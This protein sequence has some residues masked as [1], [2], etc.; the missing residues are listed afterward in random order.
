[1]EIRWMN[2]TWEFHYYW[3]KS[4]KSIIWMGIVQWRSEWPTL[5]L[6]IS[7]GMKQSN[8]PQSAVGRASCQTGKS[9]RLCLNRKL[10]SHTQEDICYVWDHKQQTVNNYLNP[11]TSLC[12]CVRVC[13][14][15]CTCVHVCVYRPAH[16][17]AA[18]W[19]QEQQI[20]INT[21]QWQREQP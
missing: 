3:K 19:L 5:T 13:V 4:F 6:N 8:R 21:S 1:M 2:F 16:A 20:S 17:W 9:L 10:Q 11:T 18:L 14:C 7:L 12:V 15:V